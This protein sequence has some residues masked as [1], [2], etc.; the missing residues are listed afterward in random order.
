[1]LSQYVKRSPFTP[2]KAPVPPKRLQRLPPTRSLQ[3]SAADAKTHPSGN[4]F[5]PAMAT[6]DAA[7]AEQLLA[8]FCGRLCDWGLETYAP[9]SPEARLLQDLQAL[10]IVLQS[11]AQTR[12]VNSC[13]NEIKTHA[14]SV[15]DLTRDAMNAKD[16]VHG[17]RLS[18]EVNQHIYD[19]VEVIQCLHS[20]A[21]ST[22][23]GLYLNS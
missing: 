17:L 3:R 8:V 15:L 16:Y 11:S 14:S 4:F 22:L 20:A 6:R 10:N 9:A 12:H 2:K 13:D 23:L 21:M 5:L 7:H 18:F 1:M 19:I